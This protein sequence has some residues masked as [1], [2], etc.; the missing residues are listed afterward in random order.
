MSETLCRLCF[1][2]KPK[3]I[4]I[5]GGKGVR[6]KTAQVI[7]LHFPDEVRTDALSNTTDKYSDAIC[8]VV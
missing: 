8:V 1:I 5:F 6:Q 4:S 3:R 2:E 7:R